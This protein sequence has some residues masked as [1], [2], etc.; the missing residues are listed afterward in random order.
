MATVQLSRE[1]LI[2]RI[3]QLEAE[4]KQ[5]NQLQF[6]VGPSGGVMVKGLG[7]WPTTLFYEQWMRLLDNAERLR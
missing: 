2:A 6:G 5:L 1:Q 3:E 7:R 4:R